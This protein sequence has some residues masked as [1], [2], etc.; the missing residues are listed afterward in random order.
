MLG[1]DARRGKEAA[2]EREHC[3]F[4]SLIRGHSLRGK[5]APVNPCGVFKSLQLSYKRP[6]SF[7]VQFDMTS[8][9]RFFSALIV[10]ATVIAFAL[11]HAQVASPNRPGSSWVKSRAGQLVFFAVLEGLYR[12]GVSN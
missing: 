7:C 2:L 8:N 4:V 12:D 9:Q 11:A 6:R 3:L 5:P 1:L 10:M